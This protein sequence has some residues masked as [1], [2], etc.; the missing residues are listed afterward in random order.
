VRIDPATNSVSAVV[1]VGAG[2]SATAV[3]GRRSVWVYNHEYPGSVSEIDAATME[4]LQT[5]TVTAWPTK[6]DAFAGP[7][8]AADRGGAWLI[9]ADRSGRSLL[10]RIPTGGRGKRE[11][12]LDR[13]PSAVA[14][15]YG[16]VWVVA[17]GE[18]DNQVLRIDPA[19]GEVTR[20]TRFRASS[21]IDGLAVGLGGVW[22][23]ASSTATLYRVDPRSGRVLAETDLGERA[24]RPVVVL[25]SIWVSLSDG[26]GDAV[27]VDPTTTLI[28]EHLGCCPLERGFDTVGFGSIWT[29]DTP[30]G[31]VARWDG[32]TH[33]VAANIRV[34][35]PP[36][37]DGECL[38]SIAA[39]AGAVWVTVAARGGYENTPSSG[40]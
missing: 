34:T 17:A 27:I 31:T 18:R 6:L 29:Y 23:V 25:G 9:G 30:T 36:F 1:D 20:R 11:Y 12:V 13:D 24:T 38:S 15:G 32:Q 35:D 33:Q 10:T 2:P 39:G 4:V 3:G 5:T 22:V 7:V 19:T 8:L 21:P 28:S 40:C 16:A 26:G 37:F 14:T